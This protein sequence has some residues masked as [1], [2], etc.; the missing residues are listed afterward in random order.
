MVINYYKQDFVTCGSY[1]DMEFIK[2]LNYL[3]EAVKNPVDDPKGI[4]GDLNQI[5]SLDALLI[6]SKIEIHY[7]K[8]KEAR[9][10]ET[11]GDIEGCFDKWKEVLGND[12]P[13]Y[14]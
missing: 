1:I 6:S 3:K 13:D 14:E 5:D 4:L 2:V 10:L 7:N 9:E 11:N 12:F 8:A